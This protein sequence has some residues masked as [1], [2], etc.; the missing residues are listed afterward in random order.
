M[1]IQS[2]GSTV[3]HLFKNSLAPST[4]RT[5][6]SS[7]K[8]YL[9]FCQ[10]MNLHPCPITQ[11]ML[12]L[13]VAHLYQD[14]L[15]HTSIKSYLSAV[16]NMQISKG[17]PDPF[18]SPL[19]QLKLV[20]RGVKVCRGLQGR[21]IPRQKLPITPSILRQLKSLWKPHA[22]EYKFIMLWAVCCTCFF[23]FFRSGEIT[24]STSHYDPSIHLSIQDI[25]LD[26]RHHPSLVQFSLKSSK[27][28]P[29]R[30]GVEVVIGHTGDDLCP[31]T[32]ILAYLAA[33][34]WSEGPLFR[35]G[36]KQPLARRQF[37]NKV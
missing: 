23:G 7:K 30:K 25:A 33:R 9:A 28:D 26:S 1:D 36:D 35:T 12:C 32:A 21:N 24:T 6:E 34:G 27:T 31:V 5:Y 16:R 13:Y 22:T 10:A 37:V 19:P 8:R 4:R 3:Q 18:A 15:A 29:F 14:G 2:L 17:M 11:G 20:I